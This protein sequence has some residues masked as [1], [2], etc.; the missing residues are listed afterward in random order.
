MARYI[1]L[2]LVN[3]QGTPVPWPG[4]DTQFEI[5]SEQSAT[6]VWIG[7]SADGSNNQIY[8]ITTPTD[9]IFA[10]W[11]RLYQGVQINMLVAGDDSPAA[12]EAGEYVYYLSL[13]QFN[14]LVDACCVATSVQDSPSPS[15]CLVDVFYQLSEFS[16]PATLVIEVDGNEV[17]NTSTPGASG[18]I[19]VPAGSEVVGQITAGVDFFVGI[20]EGQDSSGDLLDSD[21]G[22]SGTGV[23]SV[24]PVECGQDYF[25][26]GEGTVP[27]P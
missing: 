8:P 13:E 18:S 16:E 10:T 25:I 7:V 24:D 26:F 21:S 9:T 6:P 20:Y 23:A 12:V 3:D 27:P 17:V 2:K 22:S 4:T 14:R 19:Q 5:G 15:E 11:P 1:T